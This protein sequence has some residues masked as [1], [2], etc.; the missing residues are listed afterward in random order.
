MIGS[1]PVIPMGE[2]MKKEKKVS[3]KYYLISVA[4]IAVFILAWYL[5]SDVFHVCC[6]D[7]TGSLRGSSIS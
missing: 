2:E 5:A 4:A 7:L 3:S 6:R 1:Y